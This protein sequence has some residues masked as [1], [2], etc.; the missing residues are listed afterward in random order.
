MPV[1]AVDLRARIDRPP[2]RDIVDDAGMTLSEVE[3][4]VGPKPVLVLIACAEYAA[5]T[6]AMIEAREKHR[7][8]AAE[9]AAFR[10]E[11][12]AAHPLERAHVDHT[13]ERKVAEQR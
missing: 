11:L 4:G 5:A 13:G 1:R 9:R 2:R 8:A 7:V 10:G 6:C 12:A 3:A